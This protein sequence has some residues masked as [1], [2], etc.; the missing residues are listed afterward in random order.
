MFRSIA[1]PY[2]P[3]PQLFTVKTHERVVYYKTMEPNLNNRKELHIIL[4]ALEAYRQRVGDEVEMGVRDEEEYLEV[5]DL[6]SKLAN[7]LERLPY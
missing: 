6:Q 7:H 1:L 4:D 2:H 3:L 5:V